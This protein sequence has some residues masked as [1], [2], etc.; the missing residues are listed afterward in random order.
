MSPQAR[1][2]LQ[3]WMWADYQLYNY[4]N[5]KL[6][7]KLKVVKAKDVKGLQDLNMKLASS[8]NAHTVDNA[9]TK[10]TPM[11]MAHPMV[12]AYALYKNCT[13]YAMSEPSFVRLIR[14]QQGHGKPTPMH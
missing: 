3:H 14:I 6:I 8:C 9:L 10:G 4:F 2:I 5:H 7:E 11:H 1:L 12:K 13:Q